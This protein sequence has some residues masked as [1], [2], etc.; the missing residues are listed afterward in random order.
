MFDDCKWQG[1]TLTGALEIVDNCWQLGNLVLCVHST[2]GV[3]VIVIKLATGKNISF[4]F[5]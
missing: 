1:S 3:S 2:S 5:I 4:L